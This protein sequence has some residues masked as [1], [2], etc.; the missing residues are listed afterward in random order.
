MKNYLHLQ[1]PPLEKMNTALAI[2]IR[3]FLKK[4]NLMKMYSKGTHRTSRMT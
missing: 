2:I 3:N 1:E 4:V